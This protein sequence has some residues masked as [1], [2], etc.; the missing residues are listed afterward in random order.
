MR[1]SMKRVL[2]NLP[3][4]IMGIIQKELKGK[5]GDNNS[6]VIRSIVVAYL[7]E[8]GYMSKEV[9]ARERSGSH[10]DY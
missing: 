9:R 3:E 8:K 6:E 7:S 10:R 2:V 4:R 5:M 1:Y